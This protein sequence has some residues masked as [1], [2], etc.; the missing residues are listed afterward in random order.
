MVLPA[1][2]AIAGCYLS[3]AAVHSAPVRPTPGESSSSGQFSECAGLSRG[4]AVQHVCIVV[5]EQTV[6]YPPPLLLLSL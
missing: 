3:V 5:I 2:F 4:Q 6:V 1:V